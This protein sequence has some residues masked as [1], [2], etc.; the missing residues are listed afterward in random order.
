MTEMR[1][2]EEYINVVMA[3]VIDKAI[4]ILTTSTDGGMTGV[5]TLYVKG[6]FGKYKCNCDGCRLL[7][8]FCVDGTKFHLDWARS[9]K[10]FPTTFD[11]S[12][13]SDFIKLGNCIEELYLEYVK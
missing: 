10:G 7:C 11:V 5:T 13:P 1:E 9:L 3:A 6:P 4:N 8:K 2:E 12:S